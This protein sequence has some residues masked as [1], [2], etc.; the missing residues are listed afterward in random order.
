MEHIEIKVSS[1]SELQIGSIC[2]I[3]IRSRKWVISEKPNFWRVKKDY[4]MSDSQ[5]AEAFYNY[6]TDG[7]EWFDDYLI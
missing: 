2:S 1:D 5:I 3:R 6:P 7:V 4:D